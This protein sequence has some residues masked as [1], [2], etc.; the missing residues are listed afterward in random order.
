MACCL[1]VP[2]QFILWT[3]ACLL[4][5]EQKS[6]KFDFIQENAFNDVVCKIVTYFLDLKV[7]ILKVLWDLINPHEKLRRI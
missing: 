3:N 1:F 2:S 4:L 7:L 6:V 5:I